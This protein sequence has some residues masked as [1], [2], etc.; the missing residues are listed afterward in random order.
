[1]DVDPPNKGTNCKAIL[2]AHLV[3]QLARGGEHRT[4][5]WTIGNVVADERKWIIERPGETLENGSFEFFC[6]D[7]HALDA[8]VWL[9]LQ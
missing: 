2:A 8:G 4:E 6:W 1:M 3:S 9:V 7:A 5:V